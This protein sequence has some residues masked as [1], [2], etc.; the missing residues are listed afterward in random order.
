MKYHA[1][2]LVSFADQLLQ[3]TGLAGDRARVVAEILVEADLMGHSTHGLQLLPACLGEL[4][5]RAM[6]K[7]GEPETLADRGTAL[8]W[9]GRYLPGPWPMPAAPARSDPG[10]RR[11]A[12]PAAAPCSSG[13]NNF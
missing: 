4:E 12:F 13:P 5:K 1:A 10:I 6:T 11:Y 8:T 3:A 7:E 2:D 9:D